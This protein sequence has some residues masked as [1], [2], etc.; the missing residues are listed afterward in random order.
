M[1][2]LQKQGDLNAYTAGYDRFRRRTIEAAANPLLTEMLDSIFEKTPVL[3][4]RIL[5]PPGRVDTGQ[6][7]HIAVLE[8]MRRGDA[9]GAEALRRAKMRSARGA[10]VRHPSGGYNAPMSEPLEME[11]F[12]D[13]V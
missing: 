3:I 7:E 11:I 12:S 10:L 2:Q 5:I 13:Y 8:A 9:D 1:Q 4:R 6:R